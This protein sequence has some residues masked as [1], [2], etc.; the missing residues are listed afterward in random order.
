MTESKQRGT[1][2]A[3][4]LLS[5]TTRGAGIAAWVAGVALPF[6]ANATVGAATTDATA[7]IDAAM[8]RNRVRGAMTEPFSAQEIRSP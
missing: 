6:L 5:G 4:I 7:M 1:R 8:N 2:S 3:G